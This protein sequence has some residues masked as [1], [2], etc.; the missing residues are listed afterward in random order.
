MQGSIQLGDP[1]GGVDSP[2]SI[3]RAMIYSLLLIRLVVVMDHDRSFRGRFSD[4]SFFPLCRFVV[5]YPA[6]DLT[7]QGL[8]KH[9]TTRKI[10][11]DL[12]AATAG[13]ARV[14]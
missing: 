2:P 1:T 8:A 3:I 5:S 12:I 9:T 4:W 13:A 7:A 14:G 10:C 11:I 6:I